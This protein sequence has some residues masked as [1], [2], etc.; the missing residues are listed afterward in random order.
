M[1]IEITTY[2]M[3]AS[4]T[5]VRKVLEKGHIGGGRAARKEQRENA[6]TDNIKHVRG[7]RLELVVLG[8]KTKAQ[9]DMQNR[10]TREERIAGTIKA[11]KSSMDDNTKVLE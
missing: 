9:G 6:N 10:R 7:N 5:E 11:I 8:M 2:H 4:R 3:Q 1:S